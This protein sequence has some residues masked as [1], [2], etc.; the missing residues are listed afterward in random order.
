MSF[1]D[2][3]KSGAKF[4]IDPANAFGWRDENGDAEQQRNNLNAQGGAAGSWADES[5]NNARQQGAMSSDMYKSLGD[6]AAGKNLISGEMLRQGLQQQYGQ[7]R[8]MAAGASPQNAAMAA[9]TGAMN[10]GRAASGMS[11]QAALAGMQEQAAAQKMQ[12]DFLQRWR[13]QDLGAA[14][15][16]RGQSIGAYQGI[17][18][19]KTWIEKFGPAAA[20][21]ASMVAKSDERLKK[22]IAANS[23]ALAKKISERLGAHSYKYKD[24][25]HGKGKQFGPMAQE[26]EK[27]GLGHAVID[28]PEGKMVHGAKAALSGLALS[29]AL[30]RR[31]S[32]LEKDSE[33][34]AFDSTV[35]VNQG[36]DFGTAP[37]KRRRDGYTATVTVPRAFNPQ[38][39]SQ[40]P[41]T[42]YDTIRKQSVR[43]EDNRGLSRKSTR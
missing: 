1:W 35:E 34:S 28:T 29:A 2:T 7:Q 27:A 25:K 40:A 30:A 12:A 36:S 18:P 17:T 23:D 6:R 37:G 24:E 15:G 5:Q 32:K 11:G 38:N 43:H 3:V 20:G 9:R 41:K 4:A 10:M 8:S 16:A 19:D 14:Q 21:G 31:V 33:P 42:S 13:D 39:S 26:M 22:D